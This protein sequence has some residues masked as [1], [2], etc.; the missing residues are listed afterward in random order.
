MILRGRV[1]T[2]GNDVDTDAI[3]AVEHC[4]EAD[5]SSLARYCMER[6]DPGFSEKV[7][8]GDII[9]AGRN[10][11]CGSSREPAALAIKATGISC[12]VARSFARIFYRNAF[13]VGLPLLES[14]EIP[15]VLEDGD[16]VEVDLDSGVIKSISLNNTFMAKPIP[17]F[18]QEIIHDGGLLNHIAKSIR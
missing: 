3:I 2:F 18:M 8:R 11:G 13:N 4:I 12:V 7:R 1:W 15:S 16:E 9:L 17:T 10:F 14:S 5:L 6:I